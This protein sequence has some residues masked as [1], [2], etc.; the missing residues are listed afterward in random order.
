MAGAVIGAAT[1]IEYLTAFDLGIDEVLVVDSVPGQFPGRPAPLAAASL[2]ATGLAVW[3]V[4]LRVAWPSHVCALAVAVTSFVVL[5][6]YGYGAAT[7]YSFGP[8]GSIP[9]HT[10]LSFVVL[11]FGVIA[12]RDHDGITGI[13]RS[14]GPGGHLARRLLPVALLLPAVL[15]WA[16]LLGQE[17]G[18]YNT[19]FGRGVLR[20]GPYC[21]FDDRDDSQRGLDRS[22]RFAASANAS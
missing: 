12:A 17:A 16:R 3:A 6:G 18:L 1:L 22:Y 13:L 15:G 10:A 19:V 5:M 2:L 7:L 21:A 11:A 9:A 8:Y 14:Q 20:D 4:R